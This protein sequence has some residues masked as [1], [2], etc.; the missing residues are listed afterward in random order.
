MQHRN[1]TVTAS[2]CRLALPAALPAALFCLG[3]SAAAQT[4]AVIEPTTLLVAGSDKAIGTV[5]ARIEAL[6]YAVSIGPTLEALGLTELSIEPPVDSPI[7]TAEILEEVSGDATPP[8]IDS[9]GF[10]FEFGI[11]GGQTGSLWVTRAVPHTTSDFESQYGVGAIGLGA[12]APIRSTGRGVIVGVLDT[13]VFPV[14]D[15]A[16]TVVARGYD[17]FTDLPTPEGSPAIDPGGDGIDSDGDRAIDEC[18]GHGSFV[19]SI[20]ARVAPE[21]RQLHARCVDSD[22]R[23]STALIARALNFAVL[24]GAQV[25]NISAV[26]SDTP[27]VLDAAIL[28]ARARGV[29][30]VASAGNVPQNLVAYPAAYPDVACVASSDAF[31]QFSQSFSTFG[32]TVDFC[33]PGETLYLGSPAAPEPAEGREIIGIIGEDAAQPGTPLYATASG[34]SFSAAWTSGAAALVRSGRPEWPGTAIPPQSIASAIISRL[35]VT[36]AA[37]ASPPTCGGCSGN[38]GTGILNCHTAT[39]FIDPLVVPTAPFDIVPGAG[40]PR[41]DGADLAALLS[42]WGPVTPGAI[43]YADLDGDGAVTAADLARLLSN[44][45]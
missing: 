3:S 28:A 18:V 37:F 26:V 27:P 1:P 8:G 38:T 42:S 43:S 2:I 19:G 32:P 33:A 30:I 24:G 41:I 6:G 35:K 11:G 16:M 9:L 22:G 15:L 13:G 5:I 23:T 4:D 39:N 17:A 14:G 36:A 7:D 21:A 34:T 20:I 40:A 44:W 10:N 31:G 45:N 12:G 29:T 25:V